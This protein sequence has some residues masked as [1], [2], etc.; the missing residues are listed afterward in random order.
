MNYLNGYAIL[1][2]LQENAKT[3]VYR[4]IREKDLSPRTPQGKISLG[5][6]APGEALRDCQPVIMALVHESLRD[7]CTYELVVAE[8]KYNDLK[9]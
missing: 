1:E 5:E 8:N 7:S 6:I 2:T 9:H 3:I 4:G